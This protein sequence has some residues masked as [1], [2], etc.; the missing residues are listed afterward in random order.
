MVYPYYTINRYFVV[1][2]SLCPQ[3][4]QA[5]TIH[6]R[7]ADHT[8]FVSVWLRYAYGGQYILQRLTISFSYL[9]R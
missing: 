3:I 2:P 4:V 7:H 5:F 6:S 1:I 8:L 9:Q